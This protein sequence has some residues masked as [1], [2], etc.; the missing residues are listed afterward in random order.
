MFFC[1]HDYEILD[2]TIL[3]SP[4]EQIV[5]GE[6]KLGRVRTDDQA[7]FFGKKLVILLKCSKCKNI[8]KEVTTNSE[9]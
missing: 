4:Y 9:Q 6:G 8:K 5:K 1:K 3:E 2:K 7:L